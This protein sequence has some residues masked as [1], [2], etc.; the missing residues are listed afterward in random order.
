MKKAC[1]YFFTAARKVTQ[2]LSPG[3]KKDTLK[4]KAV[5]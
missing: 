2:N 1:P 5:V 3:P 4:P